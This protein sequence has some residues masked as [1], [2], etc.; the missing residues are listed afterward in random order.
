ME[1]TLNLFAVLDQAASRF[2]D[3]GA[4]YHG[5]RRLCTWLELRE[6]ALRIATTI[7]AQDTPGARIAIASENRPEIVELMFAIW[8]AE[9]VLVPVNYK[10]HPREM[11]QILDDAGV[12]QVF[13]SD[14]R[15]HLCPPVPEPLI[16]R[17]W[18]GFSTP[19]GRPGG[20]KARC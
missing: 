9:C 19:A 7:R 16:R 18:P 17:R 14:V 2:P 6:R 15:P 20:R 4:L 13:A 11:V 3:R 12:S 8:A 1:C 10:L 5:E